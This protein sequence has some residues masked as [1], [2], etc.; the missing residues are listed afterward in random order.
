MSRRPDKCLVKLYKDLLIS[1][2]EL[3]D[4]RQSVSKTLY[5]LNQPHAKNPTS[6]LAKKKICLGAKKF[7]G[8]AAQHCKPPTYKCPNC[9]LQFPTR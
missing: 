6:I 2:R 7:S 8:A 4:L 3:I 9:A 1:K 5:G